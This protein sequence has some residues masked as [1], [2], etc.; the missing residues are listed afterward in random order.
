M[1]G[2]CAGGPVPPAQRPVLPRSRSDGALCGGPRCDG[3]V[4]APLAALAVAAAMSG[5]FRLLWSTVTPV[6]S[7]AQAYG[8]GI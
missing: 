6:W 8:P 5:P 4:L 3:I 2:G 1:T 7:D